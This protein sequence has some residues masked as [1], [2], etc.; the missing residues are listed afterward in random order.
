MF[1]EI[2]ELVSEVFGIDEDEVTLELSQQTLD[3]W[4]SLNHLKLITAV[5]EEFNINFTMD[6]IEEISN[7]AKLVEVIGKYK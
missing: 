1:E 6:D 5:E 2:R 7:V 4:D 3:K